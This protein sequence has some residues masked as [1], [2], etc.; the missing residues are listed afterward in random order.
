[1]FDSSSSFRNQNIRFLHSRSIFSV[2]FFNFI[3]KLVSCSI[4]S[5]RA[6]KMVIVQIVLYGRVNG[7]KKVP[8][9]VVLWYIMYENW[10]Q[11]CIQICVYFIT[12]L[13]L[14]IKCNFVISLINNKNK[15][16]VFFCFIDTGNRRTIFIGCSIGITISISYR[17]S[18]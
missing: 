12:S 16:Y 1:M 4:P 10:I 13:D 3:K 2:E 18:N 6:D 7:G 5:I 14:T 9:F 11:I 15:L 8:R 17:F